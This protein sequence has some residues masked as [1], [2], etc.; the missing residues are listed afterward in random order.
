MSRHELDKMI[1]ENFWRRNAFCDNVKLYKRI[2]TECENLDMQLLKEEKGKIRKL[3]KG[4][5]VKGENW[6]NNSEGVKKNKLLLPGLN[7][8]QHE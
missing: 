3:V 8:H 2:S 5:E 7:E 6:K 1:I 4:W